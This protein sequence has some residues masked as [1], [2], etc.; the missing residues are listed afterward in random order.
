VTVHADLDLLALAHENDESQIMRDALAR[1]REHV[2]QLEAALAKMLALDHNAEHVGKL[3]EQ[4]ALGVGHLGA[5]IE[6]LEA[7]LRY[8]VGQDVA[9]WPG[10]L[11]PEEILARAGVSPHPSLAASQ[12][13]EQRFAG[14][15]ERRCPDSL[16]SKYGSRHC[17]LPMGHPGAHDYELIHV[18]PCP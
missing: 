1:V 16:W 10:H 5:R 9:G 11:R 15:R 4:I 12:D 14:I 2:E 18:E 8:A 17:K 6:Q 7:A 13:G 3:L